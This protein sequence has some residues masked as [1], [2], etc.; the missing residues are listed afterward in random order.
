MWL[1]R[2]IIVV[3]TLASPFMPMRIG[4]KMTYV[5]TWV[6]WSITAGGFAAF[7]LMFIL[8]SKVFPIISMWEVD[9]TKWPRPVGVIGEPLTAEGAPA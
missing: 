3:P 9:A 5:P 2:Y 7:L 4:A 1:K 8:F 6:E